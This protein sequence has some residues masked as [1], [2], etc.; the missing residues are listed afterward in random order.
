MDIAGRLCR[1]AGRPQPQRLIS[2]TGGKNNRVYRLEAEAAA[3]LVLKCYHHDPRDPRD[4]LKAEWAFL[5]YAKSRGMQTLPTPLACDTAAHAGLYTYLD[6]DRVA[7]VT[8]AHVD[9]ALAF[10]VDLNHAPGD[11]Q[12]LQPASEACFSIDTHVE[13][14]A[15]RVNRLQTIDTTQPHAARAEYVVSRHLMPAWQ[16][17][18]S[19]IASTTRDRQGGTDIRIPQSAEIVSPSDF[20]FHNALIDATGRVRFFDFEYAGRDDPAKLVCDFFCQPEVPVPVAHYARFADGV[21]AALGLDPTHRTRCDLLL[22]A[23]RIKWI[24]IMLNDFLPSGNARRTFANP[25]DQSERC[26]TQLD[27]AEAALAALSR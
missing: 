25:G 16:R 1:Q 14:V 24:C 9:Q 19:A 21:I 8:T 6:G 13:T 26:R 15:R 17:V 20:G 7:A 3:P 27:K 18:H 12:T 2:L 5:T 22:D 10:I 23:Y 4:R 11:A